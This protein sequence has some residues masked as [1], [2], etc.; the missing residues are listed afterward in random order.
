MHSLAFLNIIFCIKLLSVCDNERVQHCG[1][2]IQLKKL[3][4]SVLDQQ[5]CCEIIFSLLFK[6]AAPAQ[7]LDYVITCFVVSCC[8]LKF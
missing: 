4:F 8:T 1:A 5:H 6:T 3:H 7:L 2:L